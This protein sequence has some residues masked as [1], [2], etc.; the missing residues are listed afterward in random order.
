MF[1]Y[2]VQ[3][4]PTDYVAGSAHPFIFLTFFSPFYILFLIIPILIIKG[5]VLYVYIVDDDEQIA[6]I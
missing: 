1:I 2:A 4:V 5:S 3:F 6:Y